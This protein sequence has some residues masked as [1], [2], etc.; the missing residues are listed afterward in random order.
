MSLELVPP[1]P[2]PPATTGK[3]NFFRKQLNSKILNFFVIVKDTTCMHMEKN[4]LR[5]VDEI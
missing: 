1:P 3:Q 2:P 5:V 4:I